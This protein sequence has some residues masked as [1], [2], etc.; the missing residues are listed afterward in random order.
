[1][2]RLT[3]KVAVITGG[4]RGMGAAHAQLFVQEGATVVIADLL[5]EEGQQC[6][7]KL[8]PACRFIKL[9]V[10]SASNWASLVAEVEDRH[11][12]LHILIA[13][14][15]VAEEAAITEASDEHFNRIVTINQKGVFYAVRAV[16]PAMRRAG[17]GA[18]V[19][20]SS[21]A[22]MIAAPN[23]SVYSAS[24]GAIAAFSRAA[25]VELA[26]DGIRVNSI[27][28]GFIETAMLS[29]VRGVDQLLPLIPMGRFGK[30]AEISALA[31]FLAS[32]EASYITGAQLVADGG[33]TAM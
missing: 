16:V 20:I 2:G 5:E 3:G 9:D 11:R 12:G 29:A 28:P 4:A 33:Y 14:A 13:N 22:S 7:A 15:G 10:A 1:M 26:K 6:A 30:P 25:A 18:I 17:G 19:N 21:I 27:H 8:G 24:K 31:L 23:S 32:D